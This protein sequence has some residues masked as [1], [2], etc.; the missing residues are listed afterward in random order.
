MFGLNFITMLIKSKPLLRSTLSTEPNLQLVNCRLADL[1]ATP[2]GERIYQLVEGMIEAT[3]IVK[4]GSEI[5]SIQM[6]HLMKVC[7]EEGCN[8]P[9]IKKGLCAAHNRARD[10]LM[11]RRCTVDVFSYMLRACGAKWV[12]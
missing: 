1:K 10:G 2:Q 9:A 4:A 5:N 6:S 11:E 3:E 7:E 12:Q 8:K